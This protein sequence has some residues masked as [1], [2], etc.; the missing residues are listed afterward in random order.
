M[1]LFQLQSELAD[2]FTKHF[3]LEKDLWTNYGY[4]DLVFGRQFFKKK[5]KKKVSLRKQLTILIANDKAQVPS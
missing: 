1:Q 4:S 5:K 3:L 2:V